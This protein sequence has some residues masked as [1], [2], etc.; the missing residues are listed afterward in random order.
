[1][2]PDRFEVEYAL[3]FNLMSGKPL[4]LLV[5]CPAMVATALKLAGPPEYLVAG[6]VGAFFLCLALLFL[7][8]MN[9]K[10]F[11]RVTVEGGKV[12]IDERPGHRREFFVKAIRKVEPKRRESVYQDED[13]MGM[14]MIW[15]EGDQVYRVPEDRTLV[16]PYSFAETLARE[17]LG[18]LRR[19]KSRPQ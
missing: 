1:M 13:N 8:G 18:C 7:F 5:G 15:L 12:H 9:R 14:I 16:F 11:T 10:G 4:V 17:L 6:T 19:E 2:S 3:P